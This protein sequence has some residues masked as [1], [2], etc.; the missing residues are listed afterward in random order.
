MN[1]VRSNFT[2]EYKSILWIENILKTI[3]SIV[4]LFIRFIGG[5]P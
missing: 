1:E 4:F 5:M 2:E 3:P